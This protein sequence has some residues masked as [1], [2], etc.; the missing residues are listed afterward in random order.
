MATFASLAWSISTSAFINAWRVQS[1]PDLWY[2]MVGN[3][4]RHTVVPIVTLAI[5]EALTSA[6]S[7]KAEMTFFIPAL[8]SP[9]VGDLCL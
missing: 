4:E 6:F 9:V 7:N 2:A 3:S 5:S 8:G 1:E